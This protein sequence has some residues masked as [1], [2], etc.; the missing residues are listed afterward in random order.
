MHL[1]ELRMDGVYVSPV[2]YE[3]VMVKGKE[4]SVPKVIIKFINNFLNYLQEI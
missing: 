3:D 2:I 4:I 1:Y